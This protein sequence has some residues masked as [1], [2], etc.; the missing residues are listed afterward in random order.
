ME[1]KDNGFYGHFARWRELDRAGKYIKWQGD[2]L[3]SNW[4]AGCRLCCGP[5]GNDKPFPMAL[6]PGQIG[7]RTADDF[8]MLDADT[9]CLGA[10]GCKSDGPSG[11]VLPFAKR[12]VACGLFPVVLINGALYLYQM[13]PAAIFEP[14]AR[15]Y[16]LAREIARYLD[17]FSLA[18]LRHISLTMSDTALLEKYINLHI[19]LFDESQ[20][21]LLLE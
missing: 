17:S 11:C 3:E 16:D 19:R 14:L 8:Y 18:D 2:R 6:L 4:C 12:P 13:C 21:K 7:P 15:F 9:A 1:A 10:Q 20:K 5:Q